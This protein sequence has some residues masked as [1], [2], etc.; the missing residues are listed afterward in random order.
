[1]YLFHPIIPGILTTI[2]K[3]LFIGSKIT[4]TYHLEFQK[5]DKE[6]V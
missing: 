3:A 2:N 5:S 4:A 6:S 1:M